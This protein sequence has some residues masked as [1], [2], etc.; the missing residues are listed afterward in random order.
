M[1]SQIPLL[2]AALAIGVLICQAPAQT[3]SASPGTKPADGVRAEQIRTECVAG[4]RMIC[5]RVLKVLPEGLV[6][7]SG[8]TNLLR[9]EFEGAWLLPGTAVASREPG[10]VENKQPDSPC[11]GN[12]FV[13]DLPRPR[14]GTKVKV[15]PYEYVVLRGYPAGSFTYSSVGSIQHTVR[16]FSVGL[17]TAVNLRL[18]QNAD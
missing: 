16:R 8:Y 2:F 5:G 7:E 17:E 12:V 15:K 9:K 13:T 18:Q 3:N 11:A 4:R 6:V 10:L 14:G 1:R